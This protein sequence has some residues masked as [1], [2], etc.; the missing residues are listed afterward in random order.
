MGNLSSKT[1]LVKTKLTL[2]K[3]INRLKRNDFFKFYVGV[4]LIYNVLDSGVQQSDSVIGSLGLACK[5][6]CI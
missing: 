4:L 3:P 1:G 5:H 6:C 2:C